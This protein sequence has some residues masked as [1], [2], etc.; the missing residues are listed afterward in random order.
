MIQLGVEI[1]VS[2]NPEI[3]L[4]QEAV[5]YIGGLDDHPVEDNDEA[6]ADRMLSALEGIPE[7]ERTN[8]GLD[9]AE[10]RRAPLEERLMKLEALWKI[11]QDELKE[12]YDAMPKVH[13]Q[14][15]RRLDILEDGSS[16]E[17][18][19]AATLVDLEDLLSDIDMARDFHSLGGFTTLASMLAV[20]QPESVREAAAWAIGTAVKSEPEHQRWILEVSSNIF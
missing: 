18:E 3:K 11:R 19:L 8:L 15:S 10:L 16:S 20:S 14:L 2:G 1:D 13:E 17:L 7:D 6:R 9:V 12:A 4:S 5:E